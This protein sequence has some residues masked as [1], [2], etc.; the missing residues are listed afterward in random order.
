M[1]KRI[2]KLLKHPLITI[3]NHFPPIR[4]FLTN[5]AKEYG[6]ISD[7]E[8]K[9]FNYIKKKVKDTDHIVIA[10]IGDGRLFYYLK[11]AGYQNI[12]GVDMNLKKVL[13]YN[14]RGKGE[15]RH[16]ESFLFDKK[17]DVM[18]CEGLLNSLDSEERERYLT[19]YTQ[20][21]NKMFFFGPRIRNEKSALG[22]EPAGSYGSRQYPTDS[23]GK[24]LK[25]IFKGYT[26]VNLE[27]SNLYFYFIEKRI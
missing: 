19:N 8:R 21:F 15:V 5:Y 16:V 3:S 13:A 26:E 22:P 14:R 2:L 11:Q 6:V 9:I 1:D 25:K 27:N 23:I 4:I 18:V 7:S 17:A 20:I 12:E 24:C 10:P